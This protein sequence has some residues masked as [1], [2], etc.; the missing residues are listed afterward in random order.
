[1]PYPRTANHFPVETERT[2]ELQDGTITLLFTLRTIVSA[3][4]GHVALQCGDKYEIDVAI[5]AD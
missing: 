4:A 2:A 1:M 3:T 5:R